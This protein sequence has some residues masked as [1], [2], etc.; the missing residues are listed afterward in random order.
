MR[1]TKQRPWFR[2]IRDLMAVGVSMA[3]I[4]KACGKCGASAVQHWADGGDPKDRD[5][6]VV[7]A[8]YRKHCPEKYKA[9]MMEF[10]PDVLEY[11]RK[12]WVKPSHA[13]RGRPIPERI[14]VKASPQFDFFVGEGA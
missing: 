14:G 11:E 1:S 10:E 4:A 6:R 9:H 12:V 2:I 8:L 13:I 5:A 7:L 3:K